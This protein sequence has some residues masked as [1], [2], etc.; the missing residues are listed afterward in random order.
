MT[1]RA[2]VVFNHIPQ[3]INR[4]PQ[5]SQEALEEVGEFIRQWAH[6]RCSVKGSNS[7]DG[8]YSSEWEAHNPQRA[9]EVRESIKMVSRPGEVKV[10][11]NHIIAPKLEFGRGLGPPT[12]VTAKP[13]MRPAVDENQDTIRQKFGDR[14]AVGI[15][16]VRG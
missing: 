12:S 13:F 3:I 15:R 8:Y 1:T 16:M 11:S 7:A 2:H 10:G 6:D 9:G 14:F 5:V 4:T